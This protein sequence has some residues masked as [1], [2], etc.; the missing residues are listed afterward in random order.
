ML[1]RITSKVKMS[2]TR[3]YCKLRNPL[4][5]QTGKPVDDIER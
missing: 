1:G 3:R 4:L 5:K 2:L